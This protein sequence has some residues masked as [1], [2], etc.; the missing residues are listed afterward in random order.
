[1]DSNITGSVSSTG[2]D[3]SAEP[4]PPPD[5]NHCDNWALKLLETLKQQTQGKIRLS[6]YAFQVAP[7]IN[8]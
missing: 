5:A 3:F 7:T 1:V 4:V 8:R 2:Y 6:G